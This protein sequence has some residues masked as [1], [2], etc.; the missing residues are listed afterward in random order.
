MFTI[1][2]RIRIYILYEKK[3]FDSRES[4]KI[5]VS[6]VSYTLHLAICRC[7]LKNEATNRES[8]GIYIDKH[9]IKYD[10]VRIYILFLNL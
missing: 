6:A 4:N 10:P 1:C 9:Y 7:E 8:Q 5:R 3:I 2:C